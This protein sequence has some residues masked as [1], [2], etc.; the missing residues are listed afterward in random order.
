[1]SSSQASPTLSPSSSSWPGCN[2]WAIIIEIMMTIIIGI[3][4]LFLLL[5]EL[6]DLSLSSS[7]QPGM[8]RR[9]SRIRKLVTINLICIVSHHCFSNNH[10]RRRC[11]P[12]LHHHPIDRD[13]NHRDNCLQCQRFYHCP[14][15]LQSLLNFHLGFIIRIR[16]QSPSESSHSTT[17]SSSAQS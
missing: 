8:D 9:R 3:T 13:C 16:I 10:L 11:L 6:S 1:M 14:S 2:L 5:S 17:S 4:I 12:R 7:V 15:H